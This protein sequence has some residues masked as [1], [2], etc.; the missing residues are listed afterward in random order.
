MRIQ[1]NLEESM[2]DKVDAYAKALG[3]SR[4]AFCAFVVGQYVWSL[5]KGMESVGVSA[6]EVL[7]KVAQ[8]FSDG[9]TPL[10]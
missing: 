4:S 5:E 7:S 3:V 1:V 10:V 8:D 6:S 2:I 9:E